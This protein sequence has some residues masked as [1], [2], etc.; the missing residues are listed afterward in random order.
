MRQVGRRT[1][2]DLTASEEAAVAAAL[3][4]AVTA[5]GAICGMTQAGPRG[6]EPRLLLEMV[7]VAKAVGKRLL[8][9]LDHFLASQHG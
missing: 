7:E 9:S 4:V 5:K 3:S 8:D 6:A 2:V 1:A